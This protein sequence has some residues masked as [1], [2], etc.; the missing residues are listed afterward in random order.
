MALSLGL[1]VQVRPFQMAV[2]SSD[3]YVRVYD[4]RMLATGT[5]LADYL[6]G[7]IRACAY[8]PF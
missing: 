5:C 6:G 3:P 7:F 1:Y 8:N 4:R 2:A